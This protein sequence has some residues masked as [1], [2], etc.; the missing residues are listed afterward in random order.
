M[1]R[2]DDVMQLKKV[3]VEEGEVVIDAM[4]PLDPS[5]DM[6]ELCAWIFQ[7]GEHDAAATEMTTGGDHHETAHGDHVHFFQGA[8]GQHRWKLPL[9][10]VGEKPLEE[11]DAFGVA[12][13][14]LSEDDQQRVV[15]WGHPL[16]L[17]A[18]GS[19]GPRTTDIPSET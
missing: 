18:A 3:P 4:G 17:T 7:R 10:Q 13:A 15:W 14:M 5:E 16:T 2:F 9:R 1:L 11:G 19:T 12:V 8:N 6:I